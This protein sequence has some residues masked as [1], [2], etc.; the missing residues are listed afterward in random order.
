MCKVVKVTAKGKRRTLQSQQF[1]VFNA[2]RGL[3]SLQKN[4]SNFP[5]KG[6][7]RRDSIVQG[8][9]FT[10]L[11][12]ILVANAKRDLLSLQKNQ[13]AFQK[14]VC[15]LRRPITQGRQFN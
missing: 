6:F 9:G 8:R 12:K 7:S 15:P 2:K 11:I 4:R 5:K 3:L 1:L 13:T 10:L 14:P